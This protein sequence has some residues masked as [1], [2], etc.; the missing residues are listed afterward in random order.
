M[1]KNSFLLIAV[2]FMNVTA[3]AMQRGASAG[4]DSEQSLYD[5]LQ[6]HRKKLE[7]ETQ[8]SPAQVVASRSLGYAAGAAII[9][10][11]FWADKNYWTAD[12]AVFMSTKTVPLGLLA[13]FAGEC[14]ASHITNMSDDYLLKLQKQCED[15]TFTVKKIISI[16]RKIASLKDGID[17]IEGVTSK[18]LDELD[19]MKAAVIQKW[20]QGDRS[21]H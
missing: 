9:A 21:R 14:R 8:P 12:K 20:I 19:A 2:L 4:R 6:A 1:K 11:G 18:H 13:A 5:V 16:E 15:D 17:G 3:L 10:F 7:E